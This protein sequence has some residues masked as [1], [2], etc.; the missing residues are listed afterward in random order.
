[1]ISI[2][3]CPVSGLERR[4]EYDFHW[5]TSARQIVVRCTVHYYKDGVPV[6][7]LS[8]LKSYTRDLVASDSRVSPVDGTIYTTE[9]VD[10]YYADLAAYTAYTAAQDQYAID[11]AEYE[12]LNAQYLIDQAAFD[13]AYAEY[14][15]LMTAYN[16]ELDAYNILLEAYNE[17]MSLSPQNPENL[18]E[19]VPPVEPANPGLIQPQQPTAPTDPTI[20]PEPT[21]PGVE[22]IFEYDFYAFVLG[23]QPLILPDMIQQII[24][25]RDSEGK[26]DI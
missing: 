18:E 14:N 16:V 11:L 6:T 12:T 26:F 19:P 7:G 15:T 9:Q 20:S 25:L 4:V 2:S 17:A 3:N 13:A 24:L 8:R 22:P 21:H 23:V 10:S 5:Y 1:M